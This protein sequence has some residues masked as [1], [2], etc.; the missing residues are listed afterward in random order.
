MNSKNDNGQ[1]TANFK[2]EGVES[3]PSGNTN[4]NVDFIDN[5]NENQSR[6]GVFLYHKDN[7]N[8]IS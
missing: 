2:K 8:N 6:F 4:V 7:S 1:N 5:S 3:N